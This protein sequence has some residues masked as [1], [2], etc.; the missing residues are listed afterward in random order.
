MGA[1]TSLHIRCKAYYI[2]DRKRRNRTERHDRAGIVAKSIEA[3]GG[4]DKFNR[5]QAVDVVVERSGLLWRRK[6]HQ[7]RALVTATIQIDPPK[8]TYN[9]LAGDKKGSNVRFIWTPKLA[10]KEPPDGNVIESRENARASFEGHAWDSPW[11]RMHLIHFAGQALWNYICAPFYF[12]WPGFELRKV[13]TERVEF[14]QVW[15]VL[16]V[17]FPDDMPTHE[18]R[19]K[20]YFDRRGVLRRLDYNSDFV[21]A[22]SAA[23]YLYDLRAVDGLVWPMLRRA[24]RFPQGIIEGGP[25]AVM[26][27]FSEIKVRFKHEEKL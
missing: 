25:A 11:D 23:H 1:A 27:N 20:F 15:D 2:I 24:V 10:W 3:H 17:T 6:G 21:K 5:I 26:L 7:E 22:G 12:S 8:V 4:L 14:D 19:Q 9:N 18:K 13:G 16:E